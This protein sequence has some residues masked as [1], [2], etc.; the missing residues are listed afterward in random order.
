MVPGGGMPIHTTLQHRFLD[1]FGDL[2]PLSSRNETQAAG[3]AAPWGGGGGWGCHANQLPADLW[4]K[5][6]PNGWL[7]P[8][9]HSSSFGF[10]QFG[11]LAWF[12]ITRPGDLR[13]CCL[14]FWD[15]TRASRGDARQGYLLPIAALNYEDG[16]YHQQCCKAC[17]VRR[18]F[19]FWVCLV[20]TPR[21]L[22][23]VHRAHCRKWMG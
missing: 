4:G 16:W 12:I 14:Y 10:L 2:P 6:T 22:D 18:K 5:V 19:G 21:Q 17:G 8:V 15:N 11:R 23:L 7:L 13:L 20:V 3:S 1:P 9:C